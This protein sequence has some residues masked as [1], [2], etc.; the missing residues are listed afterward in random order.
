VDVTGESSRFHVAFL[1]ERSALTSLGRI[2]RHKVSD[3]DNIREIPASAGS[4]EVGL[5]ITKR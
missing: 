3:V 4:A 2:R 1:Q 5:I